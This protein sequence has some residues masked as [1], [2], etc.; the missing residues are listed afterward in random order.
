MATAQETDPRTVNCYDADTGT[1]EARY[2]GECS[3]RVVSDDDAARIRQKRIERTR[4]VLQAAPPPVDRSLKLVAAGTGFFITKDAAVVTNNHVVAG[5]SALTVETV[6]DVTARARLV[7]NDPVSD[8]AL[9]KTDIVPPAV[10][11]LRTPVY[12]TG[13]EIAVIGYPDLGLQAIRPVL[14]NGRLAGPQPP[15]GQR[16]AFQA[17]VRPGNSG[18]PLLDD[19]GLVIGVVFAKVDSVKVYQKTGQLVREVG[20]AISVPA[21][22]DFLDRQRI[23]ATKA[24]RAGRLVGQELFDEAKLFVARIGCW[25]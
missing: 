12:V 6:T 16:L 21:L 8:L 17:N 18:G 19:T 11:V 25:R 15:G 3:G 23:E 20:Y 24:G 10:A 4:Q 13:Q 1:V 14:V 9:L 7:A 22:I 2:V 5:C